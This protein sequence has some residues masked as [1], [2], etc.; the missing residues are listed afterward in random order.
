MDIKVLFEPTNQRLILRNSSILRAFSTAPFFSTVRYEFPP[1]ER[2]LV[3]PLA[4]QNQPLVSTFA[5]GDR[6]SVDLSDEREVRCRETVGNIDGTIYAVGDGGFIYDSYTTTSLKEGGIVLNVVLRGA[7]SNVKG[8]SLILHYE[9]HP[10][11]AFMVKW[12]TVKNDSD[13]VIN[14]V[15]MAPEVLTVYGP[16]YGRKLPEYWRYVYPVSSSRRFHAESD[17][18]QYIYKNLKHSG[19]PVFFVDLFPSSEG[20]IMRGFSISTDYVHALERD[21]DVWKNVSIGGSIIE[22][23]GA[24]APGTSG[25]EGIIPEILS[26]YGIGPD[27][28]LQPGETFESF[29]TYECFFDGAFEEGT[30]A[31]KAMLRTLSPWIRQS[32]LYSIFTEYQQ[33]N[34]VQACKESI[35]RFAEIGFEL[36]SFGCGNL[37]NYGGDLVVNRDYFPR[38]F[39]DLKEVA[40][41]ARSK[42]LKVGH[43]IGFMWALWKIDSSETFKMHPDWRLMNKDG[44]LMSCAA[45]LDSEWGAYITK[46]GLELISELNLDYVDIDG[47]YDAFLC[48]SDKHGHHT[49][50]ESEYRNWE[51]QTAFY[52]KLREMGIYYSSPQNLSPIMHGANK[53]VCG[54]Y[55]APDPRYRTVWDAILGFRKRAWYSTIIN[56]PT[57]ILMNVSETWKFDNV[58]KTDM[59]ALEHLLATFFGYGFAA[60]LGIMGYYNSKRSRETIRKWVQFFKRYRD[61]LESDVI[62]LRYP[63]GR[64]IDTIMH[65][66]KETSPQGLIMAYNPTELNLT[67][68]IIFPLKYFAPYKKILIKSVDGAVV[69]PAC[70]SNN[71]ALLNVSLE[72]RKLTY[73]ELK[74]T[75]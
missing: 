38:G 67:E 42:G 29:K 15:S 28:L 69:E 22:S 21:A 19:E 36:W 3:K 52:R 31:F 47:P 64:S 66:N 17:E 72:P 5:V 44:S 32:Y 43:Y 56:P 26:R 20:N 14:L 10:Q 37:T 25:Y 6:S 75:E 34:S 65:V 12:C 71:M 30:L 35:D 8:V 70:S 41:Y 23:N 59:D 49:P 33:P 39:K 55:E 18:F 63:D 62:H 27:A 40:D 53:L 4:N 61:I 24:Y 58:L 48:Y 68:S 13:K 73:F 45:C 46:K 54:E 57:V 1:E 9:I 11:K 2:N 60:G 50:E 7:E 16:P 51:V 74:G